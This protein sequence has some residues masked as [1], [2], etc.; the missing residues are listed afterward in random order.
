MESN[1]TAGL[2]IV[3][4]YRSFWLSFVS[5]VVF[6]GTCTRSWWVC[7][8]V[9]R[10][11]SPRNSWNRSTGSPRT[12]SSRR[13]TTVPM[14]FGARAVTSCRT[15][16]HFTGRSRARPSPKSSCILLQSKSLRYCIISSPS[17]IS[18][19]IQLSFS[20]DTASSCYSPVVCNAPVTETDIRLLS[21]PRR[22]I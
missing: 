3:R 5:L 10:H 22:N 15:P 2:R 13:T 17:F 16:R 21:W 9:R 11:S 12:A 6:G 14:R 20:L 7:F 4:W 1:G 19:R 8:R 18:S